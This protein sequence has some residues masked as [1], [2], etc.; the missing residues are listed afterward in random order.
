MGLGD[1]MFKGMAWSAVERI[2]IQAVQ[3]F[4]QIALARILTPSE[5][6]TVGILYVFIAISMVFI[7]SG[8][9]KAL[10]QKKNRTQNDIST[11][12]LFNIGISIIAYLALFFAAPFVADF[13]NIDE[14]T[15]LL[16]VLSISLVLNALFTVPMTLY[17]IELDFKALTKINF[18]AAII[19]GAVAYYMAVDG[20]G[21]W[22]L[23][24]LT[25]TRSIV[26]VILTWT[27]LKWTPSWVFSK[28][29]LKE[30]FSFGS[31]LLISS[32]LNVTVN[33]AYELVIPKSSSIQDLGYYTRGTQF[34]NVVF[35]IINSIFERVLLPALTEVQDKIDILVNHTRSI[36]RSAALFTVPIFLFLAVIAEPLIRILIGEKWMPAVP[37][38]Q[39]FCFARLITILSGINVNLLYVI[40]RTDLAL[41][42][43]YLKIIVRVIF[44]LIAL[45]FGIIYIALAELASTIV[46]FFI[47]TYHPGKIMSYGAFAQIRDIKFIVLA[48]VLMVLSVYGSIYFINNDILRLAIAP[49]VAFPVYFGL[50][51]LFKIKELIAIITKLKEFLKTK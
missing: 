8:F 5:Y 28:A 50:V 42:Q 24:G 11:V 29:S 37:I 39:I 48:G 1:K 31:N 49:L 26:T 19:S 18:I 23:V 16:R 46:H 41:K 27:I 17:T 40:G 36:I 47:N 15:P 6:G 22:A 9:T 34:T 30:L 21:V 44:L 25:I 4:I 43:Q 45:K 10:I 2:S 3:F 33:K 14:L 51:H 12:F 13:Y 32:L 20:Y 38:M 7:D 35:S